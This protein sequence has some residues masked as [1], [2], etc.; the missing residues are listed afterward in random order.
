MFYR[1]LTLIL[2]ALLICGLFF[3]QVKE[4]LLRRMRLR[5]AQKE[6]RDVAT[7][8]LPTAP[9]HHRELVL[10]PQRSS[11]LPLTRF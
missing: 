5:P 8:V 1:S 2:V 11:A 4:S 6:H 10:W 9:T 3:V 7:F